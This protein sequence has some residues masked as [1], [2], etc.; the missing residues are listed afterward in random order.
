MVE[1]LGTNL[2]R[3]EVPLPNSPLKMLNAYCIRGSGTDRHL[4]IDNGFNRP[5]CREALLSALDAI[6]ADRRRMDFFLTHLHADHCGLTADLLTDPD[7]KIWCSADDGV[8]INMLAQGSTRWRGLLDAMEAHG[9]SWEKLHKLMRSH[10]AI[11]YA[12]SRPLPFV[13]AFEGDVLEYG[14]YRLRVLR[15]PG[16]TPEQLCLYAPDTRILFS[17]DHILGDISPNIAH[18]EGVPDSLGNYLRSL[19]KVLPLDVSLCLPGH[20]SIFAD[21]PGRIRALQ[22]HH[23]ARLDEVRRILT[24]GGLT[25]FA[26][27]G[28][29]TWAM[30]FARWED[31]PVAQQWFACGEALAHLEHLVACGEAAITRRDGR[32]HFES[33][34]P[35]SA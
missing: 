31:F 11:L 30:R 2:F 5:E 6:G 12:T 24:E 7:S 22:A 26:V 20:R 27:A 8:L 33:T 19:E 13:P 29:M 17:A 1:E 18:W 25:A 9:V 23:A 15:V 34:R 3:I 14:G 10:P 4:L 16:H 21:V 35:G 32:I 28:R